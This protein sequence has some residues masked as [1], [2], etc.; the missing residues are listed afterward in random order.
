MRDGSR[1]PLRLGASAV[2]ALWV[3]CT[4]P[5]SNEPAALPL[6]EVAPRLVDRTHDDEADGTTPFPR[7]A[8]PTDFS[9]GESGYG[10]RAELR[11]AGPG[12]WE[13]VVLDADGTATGPGAPVA[14]ARVDEL[15]LLA[16]DLNAAAGFCEVGRR[17]AMRMHAAG[18]DA[19]PDRCADDPRAHRLQA[20]FDAVA[21]EARAAR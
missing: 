5:P 1:V 12:A 9:L 6:R 10:E 7:D 20:R 3:A 2:V 13:L 15:Y 16:V 18:L 8:L 19:R 14:R 17:D 4:E 21:A 11:P